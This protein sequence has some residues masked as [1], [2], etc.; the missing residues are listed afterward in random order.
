MSDSDLAVKAGEQATSGK[1]EIF[2]FNP[3]KDKIIFPETHPY[4]KNLSKEE[5]N[6]LNKLKKDK[7]DE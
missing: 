3:G 6:T 2:R 4:V 1:N 5:K 7:T